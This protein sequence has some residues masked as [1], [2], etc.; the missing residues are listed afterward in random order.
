[1]SLLPLDK[2]FTVQVE[3][4]FYFNRLWQLREVVQI[5]DNI[6]E[7][8]GY[9]GARQMLTKVPMFDA[10]RALIYVAELF[11]ADDWVDAILADGTVLRN[12]QQRT[13]EWQSL[14]AQ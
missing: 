7:V 5:C 8:A 1:M 9:Y 14:T 11:Q 12:L 4:F 13:V 2:S 3:H 10:R 6:Y